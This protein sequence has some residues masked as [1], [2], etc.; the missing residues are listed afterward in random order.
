VEDVQVVRMQS[1][2]K[3]AVLILVMTACLQLLTWMP[4]TAS[5]SSLDIYG[6]KTKKYI[7][8]MH[9]TDMAVDLSYSRGLI[10]QS[11]WRNKVLSQLSTLSSACESIQHIHPVPAPLQDVNSDIAQIGRRM[12]AVS[13]MYRKEVK[14]SNPKLIYQ[15]L[16]LLKQVDDILVGLG[17]GP[18]GQP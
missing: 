17:K 1:L 7:T 4:C 15:S 13:A 11:S 3:L 9:Y 5:A 6:Q 2:K 10:G 12:D 16:Q 18:N 14:S 8:T